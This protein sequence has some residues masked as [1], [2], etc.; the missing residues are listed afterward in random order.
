LRRN[1]VYTVPLGWARKRSQ[2]DRL[3]LKEA[4][5]RSKNPANEEFVEANLKAL[6][7]RGADAAK[8]I[9]VTCKQLYTVSKG[10]SAVRPERAVRFK[11]RSAAALTFGLGCRLRM[12]SRKGRQSEEKFAVAFPAA[13]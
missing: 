1:L 11:A 3:S 8:A 5:R 4:G 10:G 9:G 7:L 2:F 13:G 6:G 12:T